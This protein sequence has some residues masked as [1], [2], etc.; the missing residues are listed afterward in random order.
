MEALIA[1]LFFRVN[2]FFQYLL[3][4]AAWFLALELTRIAQAR[5]VLLQ[6]LVSQLVYFLLALS[7]LV[8][9]I[10]LLLS[11]LLCQI[12]LFN[13][14]PLPSSPAVVAPSFPVVFPSLEILEL[15]T[16]LAVFEETL[17]DELPL[18]LFV[19]LGWHL[20]SWLSDYLFF[21][22]FTFLFL[23]LFLF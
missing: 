16:D 12:F 3:L 5:A 8:Q 22:T 19:F 14:K 2:C 15:A 11:L 1:K 23:P 10:L 21:C 4:A 6:V 9:S 7:A 20:L 17:T 13:R 18:W